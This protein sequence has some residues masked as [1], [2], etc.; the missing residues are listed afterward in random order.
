MRRQEYVSSIRHW[1]KYL[2]PLW[3]EEE[4]VYA[5]EG[6]MQNASLLPP[7]TV[8]ALEGDDR[9]R[10]RLER[11]LNRLVQ[12][13]PWDDKNHYFCDFDRLGL[14]PHGAATQIGM[15]LCHGVEHSAKLAFP[16]KLKE[17]VLDR[18]RKML[19]R[20]ARF[21]EHAK[22]APA[23]SYVDQEGNRVSVADLIAKKSEFIRRGLPEDFSYLG[24]IGPKNQVCSEMRTAAHLYRLTRDEKVWS[25][26]EGFWNRVL[27]RVEGSRPYPFPICFDP[28][29][30]FIYYME[31]S[32]RYET[33]MYSTH[34]F[35]LYADVVRI[36]RE[37]GRPNPAWEEFI[38]NWSA[39]L[40][41]RVVQN[42]GTCN[43]VLN[44]YGWERSSFRVQQGR[45]SYIPL[46]P[47]LTSLPCLPENSGTW[48]I[49]RT[50]FTGNGVLKRPALPGILD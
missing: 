20:W 44:G 46:F 3:S 40:F 43:M 6:R 14:E 39:A 9:S 38:R 8:L 26:V 24:E 41:T 16:A 37:I 5:F 21:S 4:G 12:T 7:L 18:V 47:S 50:G 13:P 11:L 31:E 36:A 30:S 1:M 32:R 25:W 27:E 15:L 17:A 42:D 33:S 45:M 22:D 28:D 34:V 23:F 35:G 10:S 2:E 48:L 49:P 19:A 29:Y